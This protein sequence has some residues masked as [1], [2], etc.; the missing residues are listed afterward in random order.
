MK[1]EGV[2]VVFEGIDGSGKSTQVRYLQERLHQHGIEP[3]FV[4][5][6]GGTPTGEQVRQI[7]L[8]RPGE[9]EP[10]TELLLYEASRSELT[11]TVIRPALL[12]GRVVLADRFAMASLAYQG[13]GRGLSLALVEHLNKIATDGLEPSLTIIL[14]VPVE[15]ALGRKRRAFDRL[16]R[17]GHEFHERVRQGYRQL[18]QQ[19]SHSVLIEGTKPATEIAAQ[20]WTTIQPLVKRPAPQR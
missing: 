20:I 2:F 19:T 12:E 7:L 17:A 10:L 11:R 6:P 14:D 5:E 13:H 9:M 1:S 15:I 3:L 18:A 16:E 8:D 4:R